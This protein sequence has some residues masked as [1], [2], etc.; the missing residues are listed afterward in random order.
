MGR[1][2]ANEGEKQGLGSGDRPHVVIVGAG[3]AGLEAARGLAS[4]PVR[5]TLV[6]RRNYHLFQPLLYQVATAGLSPADIATP[7]RSILRDCDNLRVIMDE[8]VGADVEAKKLFT[9]GAT[10]SYDYLV[11]APGSEYHYF[12]HED[13][14]GFAPGLKGIEDATAIR[15]NILLAFERAE[16][17]SSE[18]E[19]R[20]LMSFVLVGAGPT[21]VETAGAIAEL[22]KRALLRDFRTI[23]PNSARV[24]LLEAAPRVLPGYPESLSAYARRALERK[25]VD[26]R[27]NTP[28]EEVRPDGVV[29]GGE[30]IPCGTV[31]WCAGVA[32]EPIGPWL[33]AETDEGGRVKVSADLSLPGFP[34]VFVIGDAAHVTSERGAPLPGLATVAKQ[35]GAFVA[36]LIARRVR[37]EREPVRFRYRDYGQLAT[38]GRSAAV[39]D[40]GRVRLRGWLAWVV[41][42]FAHIYYLIGFRNRLVVF[43]NWAWAYV[44]FGRGA[45]LITEVAE[46]PE[47]RRRRA[48]GSRDAA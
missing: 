16:T 19:R 42:S 18:T 22:A 6:D 11:L 8:A 47:M 48:R 46:R 43:I 2:M 28:V 39:A 45:R 12:G 23:D 21:G 20:R 30:T 27:L 35:E 4:A 10:L 40:F 41:W 15:R 1:A 17:A 26:V 5:A 24:V 44:T 14:R 32:A 7:V 33:K 38:I 29:A 13:W 34:D 25:G 37:G 31:I 36:E 9:R 3:F